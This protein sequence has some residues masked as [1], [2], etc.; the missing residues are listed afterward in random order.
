MEFLVLTPP[1]CSPSEPAAGAFL[2]AAGLA[3]RGRDAALLDL[4]LE[5]Y[6]RILDEPAAGDLGGVRPLEYI[7]GASG[8]PP[9][10]GGYDPMRHRSAASLLHERLGRFGALH[11]GWRL[12]LMDIAPPVR[13]HDVEALSRLLEDPARGPFGPLWG[14]VLDPALDE[15]RPRHVVISLAYLSQLPAAIDL[16]RHLVRR[17][18]API[19]GGSLPSSLKLTGSGLADLESVFPRVET[20]DG[21]VLLPG[22]PGRLLDRFAWPR[23]L[24]ARE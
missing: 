20:G 11:P 16:A 23:I 4:S 22:E 21:M 7:L 24:S 3:G 9:A 18:I 19:V 12:T 6:H 13:V 14:E 17:G 1:V 15:H 8:V 10:A 5:L 2:L